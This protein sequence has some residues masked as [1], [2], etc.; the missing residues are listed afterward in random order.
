MKHSEF[1]R[2]MDD[3]FGAAYA[4]SVASDQH[5]SAL[6]SRTP[7]EALD[8]GV[9]VRDIWLAVCDAMEVPDQR[10]VG[11]VEQSRRS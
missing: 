10:R 9:A 3:E 8:A 1:W 2:L 6:G 4:R 7:S 11:K 5:L